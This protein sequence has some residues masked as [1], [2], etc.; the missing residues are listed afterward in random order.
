[1]VDAILLDQ[2]RLLL[3]AT[4]LTGEYGYHG[5]F[6]G[7]PV[8]LGARG[9]EEIVEIDQQADERVALDRSAE[10]VRELIRVMQLPLGA[11]G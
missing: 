9:V 10:A 7:V 4:Y 3:C 5:I 1:M 6:L 8:K 2:K 11:S